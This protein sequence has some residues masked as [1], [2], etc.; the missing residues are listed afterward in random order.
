MAVIN[1]TEFALKLTELIFMVASVIVGTSR[2]YIKYIIGNENEAPSSQ[3]GYI[4]H[5]RQLRPRVPN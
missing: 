4:A 5:D 3:S 2:G 1:M